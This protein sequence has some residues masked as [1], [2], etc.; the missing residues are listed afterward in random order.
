[1]E[2]KLRFLKLQAERDFYLNE[3]KENII[4]A[5]TEEQINSGIVYQEVLNQIKSGKVACLKMKRELPLTKLKPYITTAEKIGVKYELVDALNFR[6]KIGLVVVSKVPFDNEHR[7][8]V[9]PSIEDKFENVG[10]SREYVKYF[11]KKICEKHYELVKNK[12]PN[13]ENRFKKINFLDKLIGVNCP[14]CKLEK[15]KEKW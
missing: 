9:V 11:E 10:L 2:E 3:F 14:I 15:E 6:G 7:E 4:I 12:I 8:V 1:M 13:Y 5:L